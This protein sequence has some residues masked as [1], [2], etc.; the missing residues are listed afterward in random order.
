METLARDLSWEMC[1][2]VQGNSQG[3]VVRLC[4]VGENFRGTDMMGETIIHWAVTKMSKCDCDLLEYLWHGGA[5][6]S[7]ENEYGATPLR[8]AIRNEKRKL[9]NCLIAMGERLN[10][11]EEY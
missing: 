5:P 4:L 9:A 3:E 8:M 6:V 1:K 10:L 2:A 11:V 7:L